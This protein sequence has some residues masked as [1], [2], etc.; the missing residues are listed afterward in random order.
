M[1]DRT[2]NNVQIWDSYINIPSSQTYRPYKQNHSRC[3]D[4]SEVYIHAEIQTDGRRN[5]EADNLDIT[6]YFFMYVLFFP[7]ALWSLC[8]LSL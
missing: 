7:A 5:L 8:Q 2:M 6:Q 3:L 1:K 4:A